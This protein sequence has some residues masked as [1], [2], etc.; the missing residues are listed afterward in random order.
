MYEY[1]YWTLTTKLT[2]AME[3]SG[4]AAWCS[5]L[6]TPYFPFARFI[7]VSPSLM[8]HGQQISRVSRGSDLYF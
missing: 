7:S 4:I 5:A 3:R 2:T 1:P 8:M 6:L